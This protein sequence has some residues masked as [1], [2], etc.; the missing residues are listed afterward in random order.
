MKL[1]RSMSAA[2]KNCA[3]WMLRMLTEE[4]KSKH[5]GAVL[6]F[7]VSY[8]LEDDNYLFQIATEYETW[9]SHSKH[10]VLK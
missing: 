10:E 7:V 9:A 2:T 5:M 8:H 4:H 6:T 3:R 1:L